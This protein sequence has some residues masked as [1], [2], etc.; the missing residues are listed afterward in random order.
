[1]MNVILLK[2]ILC[3]AALL[4]LVISTFAF[5]FIR[6]YIF[7]NRLF[8]SNFLYQRFLHLCNWKVRRLSLWPRQKSSRSSGHGQ[9]SSI[10]SS[11]WHIGDSRNGNYGRHFLLSGPWQG[12]AWLCVLYFLFDL[13][14]S[15]L[16][17]IFRTTAKR[18]PPSQEIDICTKVAQSLYEFINYVFIW[19]LFHF[20]HFLYLVEA[21][22][23]DWP[24]SQAGLKQ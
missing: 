7:V 19:Y 3:C 24:S 12:F 15:F 1:M 4:F 13:R 10:D 22:F 21:F 14:G 2:N 16:K 23:K 5:I 18:L 11:R 17:T 20:W 9:Q 8:S 6:N